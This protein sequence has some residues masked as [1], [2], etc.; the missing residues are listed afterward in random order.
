MEPETIQPDSSNPNPLE[1]FRHKSK[2][3]TFRNQCFKAKCTGWNCEHAATDALR[4][5]S[6]R[7]YRSPLRQNNETGGEL[8]NADGSS[9]KY[10]KI[11]QKQESLSDISGLTAIAKETV[12]Q[13]NALKHKGARMYLLQQQRMQSQHPSSSSTHSLDKF[14]FAKPSS[15][16]YGAMV[17]ENIDDIEDS[18][19][20]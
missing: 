10:R 16:R 11:D 2:L 12:A 1:Q 13:F 5:S 20:W 17:S 15:L 6:K 18:E 19:N 9:V 14:R 7:K 8:W 4:A 3:R